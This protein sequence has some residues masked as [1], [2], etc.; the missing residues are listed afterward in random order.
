VVVGAALLLAALPLFGFAAF[1]ESFL[2]LVFFWVALATSWTILS[3]FSGYFS[4]GHGAFFGAGMYA[5]ANLTSKLDMPFLW[6]LPVAGLIAMLLGLG[7]G[8]VVFRVKRLRGELFALL[9]LA[10]TFI[11]ATIVLNTSLDGGPGVFLSGVKLPTV[12]DNPSSTLYLFGL[13]I[14]LVSMAVAWAVQYGRLGRGLFAIADD[15]DVAEV[16]GVPTFTY[17]LAAFALS[18]FLAGVAGGIHA[19]FVGYVT[20][21]ETFSITVPL[22]V[23][24]MS[25]LGGARHWFGPA[26]GAAAVTA[27]TYAFVGGEWALAGRAIVGLTLVLAI[28]F[29]PQ[30]V[31]GV[32]ARYRRRRT[33][34][35]PRPPTV[36]IATMPEQQ[37]PA[38][39]APG[40]VLLDCKGVRLAFRGVTALAGVDLE[41][42]AGEIL[43]L[44]G[45]NGSGKSTLINVV[46]GYYRPDGGR[47]AF[48]GRDL[49]QEAGHRIARLGVA[50]TYQIPRPFKRLSVLDNVASSAMFGGAALDRAHAERDAWQWLDFVGLA[51]RARALPTELNLHQRKFLELARALAARPRLILLDEVLAGLTPAEID[52]AIAL[53]RRIR[54]H[55][56]TILFVE[57][58][59]RAVTA[60]VDRMVVLNYGEV[61]AEGAPRQVMRAPAVIEAYLGAT[62]G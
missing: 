35:L 45:P 54:D 14:A 33:R 8:A 47:I 31:M 52:N 32:V 25:V 2:Y 56:A 44:V 50:R 41:V 39:V 53:V 48:A 60:L 16:L 3:G 49:A 10:V 21:A 40:A 5:T 28:L 59:M 13:L 20:V 36:A 55:G 43:G 27:L 61:I 29:L 18:C 34:D 23:V 15:E 19:V 30:G 22:Y 7:V 1:Y 12:Y 11:L 24:L 9:T 37:A 62:H 51:G 38:P 42:R 17:K 6:T 4:F 46:S 57:H 58:N 26:I